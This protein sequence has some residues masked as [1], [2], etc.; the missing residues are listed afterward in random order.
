MSDAD[1]R[2]VA[3]NRI[4]LDDSTL[5]ALD[6]MTPIPIPAGRYWYDAACG[7][8]GFESGPCV[9]FVQPGL[10][11]PGP[12]P[13]D[14]SGGG[15][16]IWINARELHP[17][18]RAAIIARYGTAWPGRYLLNAVGILMTEAG[19]PIANLAAP[20]AGGGGGTGMIAGMGGFGAVVDGGVVFNMPDGSIHVG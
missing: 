4:A 20:P 8:W 19:M 14:I 12:M 9:G 6:Q 2:V 17:Q 1:T 7:A 10:A 16:G 11:L 13:P 3:F 5:A 18:D 15:T